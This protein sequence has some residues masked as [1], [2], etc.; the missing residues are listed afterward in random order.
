M[1]RV[2][3]CHKKHNDGI[4]MV[5]PNVPDKTNRICDNSYL[6]VQIPVW[7][8]VSAALHNLSVHDLLCWSST[9]HRE[10]ESKTRTLQ[11]GDDYAP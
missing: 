2:P 11:R 1:I 6:L 3:K 7:S 5:L 10:K 8:S 4:Y 9:S